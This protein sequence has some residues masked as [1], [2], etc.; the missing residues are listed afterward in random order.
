MGQAVAGAVSLAFTYVPEE[1]LPV[2]LRRA[3]GPAVAIATM[4]KLGIGTIPVYV[5]GEVSRV[6]ESNF[7]LCRLLSQ[8]IHQQALTPSF[9]PPVI[10]ILPFTPLWF[11]RQ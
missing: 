6:N 2:W 1:I 11:C 7:C 8:Y 3:V 9:M 5:Y 10:T 4:A